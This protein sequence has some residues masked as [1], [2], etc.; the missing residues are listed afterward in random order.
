MTA[1]NYEQFAT[2]YERYHEQGFE[3]LAFPCNQF[4]KQE[5]KSNPEIKQF[6]EEHGAK[7]PLFDKIKVNGSDADP[8]YKFLR[9]KLTGTLSSAIKWNFTKFLCDRTG[10]PRTRFGPYTAPFDFEEDLKKLLAE[11]VDSDNAAAAT[12]SEVE[13]RDDALASP[14]GEKSKDVRP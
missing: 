2:L 8:I 13:D 6:A 7:Y 1:K 11:S 14:R 5:P 4:G 3:I 12:S 10:V 9:A